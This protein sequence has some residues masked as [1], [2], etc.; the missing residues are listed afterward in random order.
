MES[1]TPIQIPTRTI[2]PSSPE[3]VFEMS[4][5][6]PDCGNSAVCTASPLAYTFPNISSSTRKPCGPCTSPAQS[7]CSKPHSPVHKISGFVPLFQSPAASPTRTLGRL[8]PPSSSFSSSPWILP[9]SRDSSDDDVSSSPSAFEFDKY[10]IQ[11]IESQKTL[12]RP[13][14]HLSSVRLTLRG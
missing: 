10:L 5:L 1:T 13:G 8:S 14:H 6:S 7:A 11:R 2:M 4:P 3:L 9:G 12:L